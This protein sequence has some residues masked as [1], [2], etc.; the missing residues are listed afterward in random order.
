M[1]TSNKNQ[2]AEAYL[3]EVVGAYLASTSSETLKKRRKNE[4]K[5]ESAHVPRRED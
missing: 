5:A 1:H 3:A 2:P 4:H